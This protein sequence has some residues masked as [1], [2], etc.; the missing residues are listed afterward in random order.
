MEQK[1]S[2][3]FS[4]SIYEKISRQ[5]ELMLASPDFKATPL[6]LRFRR[7][8]QQVSVVCFSSLTPDT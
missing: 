4:P 7:N 8:L 5:L 3:R 6:Q 1:Q 2:L